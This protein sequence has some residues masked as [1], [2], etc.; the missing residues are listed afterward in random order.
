MAPT[1]YRRYLSQVARALKSSGTSGDQ[2]V[3]FRRL[4]VEL[5]RDRKRGT[6]LRD[7]LAPRSSRTSRFREPHLTHGGPTALLVVSVVALVPGLIGWLWSAAL[8]LRYVPRGELINTGPFAVVKHRCTRLWRCSS[9][10][11]SPP[12][13]RSVT[14]W[15]QYWWKQVS[16]RAPLNHMGQCSR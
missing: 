4:G 1:G 10:P 14:V 16:T 3:S 12:D 11:A 15:C 5:R 7:L 6:G 13:H 2:K 9:C 8:I